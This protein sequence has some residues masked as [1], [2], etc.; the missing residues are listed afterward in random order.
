MN[1]P[2]IPVLRQ[3]QVYDSLEKVEV[4]SHRDGTVLAVISQVN[5]GIIRRDARKFGQARA[6]LKRYST[7]KLLELCAKAGELFMNASLPLGTDGGTQ[8]PQE[9]LQALS[10]TSGLPQT[11][12]RMN[13]SKVY[14]VFR[15]MPV[16]LKGL[17]R[18]LDLSI[19]DAGS[20]EQDG[21]PVSYYATTEALG[22]VLPSNSPAVNSLWM[23]APVL[24]I[25][26]VIKPGR[27]EPWTPYRVIQA[28]IAAGF[29]PE[30]FSFYGTDHEGANTVLEVCGRGLAF[31]DQSTV[32]RYASNPG[33]SV[34]G[35]GY[36]KVILGEDLVDQWRDYVDVLVES[37]AANGGRS[38]INASAILVPRHGKEIAEEVGRRL[39]AMQALAADDPN[40]KLSAFANVKMAEFIDAA[41]DKDL[42]VP[43]ARD[44]TAEHRGGP[45]KVVVDGCTFLLPTLVWCDSTAHPLYNREFLFPY[46][47]VTQ[48]PQEELLG[49]IGPTLVLTA[50]TK[51]EKFIGQLMDCPLIQRLNVGAMPTSR[52]KW[53]QPHEGNLFEFLYRRRAIQYAGA[54]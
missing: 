51:D 45:R 29:P 9:Y 20:G 1:V 21:V 7:A 42:A 15:Q 24:K 34:H 50:I 33:I 18:G 36:S 53:D 52:V 48:V 30:A 19:L 46:A 28:F 14:D 31:G 5:A 13:M 27:E 40:A 43:G 26:V 3:G 2:H 12:C 8:S 25:P 37:I 17:T 54:V 16:I 6:A 22:V 10:S 35:P 47:T 23:P 39:A 38:C 11:L 4:K 49:K 44:I 41:V 32:Q